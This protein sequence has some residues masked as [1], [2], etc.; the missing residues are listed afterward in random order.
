MD[1]RPITNESCEPFCRFQQNQPS[2]HLAR[3]TTIEEAHDWFDAL[4]AAGI[5]HST[6]RVDEAGGIFVCWVS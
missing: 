2:Q 5:H 4:E 6:V 1:R 3:V